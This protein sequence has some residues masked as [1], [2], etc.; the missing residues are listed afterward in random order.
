MNTWQ[1]LIK[2]K[3]PDLRRIEDI[4][5]LL[6]VPDCPYEKPLY[7]MYRDLAPDEKSHEWLLKNTIRYD[8][9]RIPATTLCGEYVKTKGHYHP[10]APGGS[11]Y[12][13][14]YEVLH[15]IAWYLIQK[16]DLSSV[17]LIK[18][19]TGDS[20]I[21]PPGYGH[22]T[23]NP[24]KEDL[25]MANLVSDEFQSRYGT[26]ETLKGAAYYVFEDG[27]IRKNPAYSGVSPLKKINAN[28]IRIPDTLPR[29]SLIS[30]I[31]D[32]KR[33]LFLNKPH[34][35]PELTTLIP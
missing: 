6:A 27:T 22:V 1:D 13:E 12:P 32:E 28:D 30:Y 11:S 35:F 7:E 10:S 21:I 19:K 16:Q 15:G 3:K 31:G 5:D 4:K 8:I 18:A 29:G 20:V 25:V 33:L 2:T 23:I 26:Y 17:L 34:L 24:G 9:T 14:I